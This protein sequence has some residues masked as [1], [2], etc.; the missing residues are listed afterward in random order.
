MMN[1]HRTKNQ[2]CSDSV[3]ERKTNRSSRGAAKYNTNVQ[4]RMGRFVVYLQCN[5]N[6]SN[7]QQG[8]GTHCHEYVVQLSKQHP[9]SLGIDGSSDKDVKKMNPVNVCDNHFFAVCVTT[10]HD[11]SKAQ[12]FF[13]IVD[14]QFRVDDIPWKWSIAVSV[15][16]DNTNSMI[17]RKNSSASW[18][19][20]RNPYI[21]VSGF[22]CHLAHIAA[23]NGHD[24]FA[25]VTEVA[26][27]FL[28]SS[29]PLF[30]NFNKLLQ[31][32]KPIIHMLHNFI[33]A[34]VIDG[35][36]DG[37]VLFHYRVDVL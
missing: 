13:D 4:D 14:E 21:F 1:I 37:E 10:G 25:K 11:V 36:V 15:G 23:G 19:T 8:H 24:A 6:S 28:L 22:P 20:Q 30:N 35:E 32:E 33:K 18:C 3:T 16:V 31:S 17:G 34:T 7:Y 12:E 29:I 26:L 2:S 9:F 27:P 5:K